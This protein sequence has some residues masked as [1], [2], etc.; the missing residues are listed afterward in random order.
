MK[1][2]R[3]FNFGA[4]RGQVLRRDKGICVRCGADTLKI[5][6]ILSGLMRGFYG[7][8]TYQPGDAEA[9]R[10]YAA[11]LGVAGREM[12]GALWDADHILEVVRG[13]PDT[14]TNLQ[15][16]CCGCHRDKTCRLVRERAQQRRQIGLQRRA[17]ATRL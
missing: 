9:G 5:R 17:E 11:H 2:R 13:G 8:D 12:C 1:R 14:L 6:R 3:A 10:W 4:L 7:F 15:T 16:L